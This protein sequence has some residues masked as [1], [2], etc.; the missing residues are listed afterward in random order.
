MLTG[1]LLVR[2]R[3]N[4]LLVC[5]RE[6]RGAQLGIPDP[7]PECPDNMFIRRR[8]QP[9]QLYAFDKRRPMEEPELVIRRQDDPSDTP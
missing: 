5:S 2:V 9:I 1:W 4:M 7:S 3:L 6:P 8:L